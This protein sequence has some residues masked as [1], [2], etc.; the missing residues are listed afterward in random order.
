MKFVVKCTTV[1]F[2][3]NSYVG[4]RVVTC[5]QTWGRKEGPFETDP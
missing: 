5:E 3:E 4:S 1:I 2:D